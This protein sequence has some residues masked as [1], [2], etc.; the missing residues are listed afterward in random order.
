MNR[1]R[2]TWRRRHGSLPAACQ[3]PVCSTVVP[4]SAWVTIRP[5]AAIAADLPI[6]GGIGRHFSMSNRYRKDCTGT[7]GAASDREFLEFPAKQGAAWPRLGSGGAAQ[8][9]ISLL[10]ANATLGLAMMAVK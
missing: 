10:Q 9:P 8:V 7:Q 5:C 6:S 4:N 2:P 3:N 1:R